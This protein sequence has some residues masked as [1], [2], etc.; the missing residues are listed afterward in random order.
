[1]GA[2]LGCGTDKEA[3]AAGKATG[4]FQWRA[5]LRRRREDGPRIDTPDRFG[6]R[7]AQPAPTERRPP[8]Q[9]KSNQYGA[10]AAFQLTRM[11]RPAGVDAY[12]RT[13][14]AG[15]DLPDCRRR[16]KAQKIKRKRGTVC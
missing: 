4:L 3:R 10:F 13:G 16:R 9:P 6:L 7:P 11:D 14:D 1:M 2:S 8:F 12:L 15:G 5:S